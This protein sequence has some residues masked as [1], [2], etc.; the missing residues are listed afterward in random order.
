MKR[1]LWRGPPFSPGCGT[2][3]LSI[4]SLQ[5]RLRGYAEV[6]EVHFWQLEAAVHWVWPSPE[7]VRGSWGQECEPWGVAAGRPARRRLLSW[8]E[9]NPHPRSYRGKCQVYASPEPEVQR[10]WVHVQESHFAGTGWMLGLRISCRINLGLAG[11]RGRMGN[12][13][14]PPKPPW[15]NKSTLIIR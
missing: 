8:A 12:T 5:K 6:H 10:E 7:K 11:K 9:L 1:F 14:A 3:R 2:G 15:E 13:Q 4:P